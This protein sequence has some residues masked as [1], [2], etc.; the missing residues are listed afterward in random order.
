MVKKVKKGKKVKKVK[1]STK[2][3]FRA[4]LSTG[5]GFFS[6]L[7]DDAEKFFEK[8]VKSAATK[9]RKNM[10]NIIKCFKEARKDVQELKNSM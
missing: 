1:K 9:L 5:M 4:N 3:D 2:K 7:E 6:E 10:L 8:G